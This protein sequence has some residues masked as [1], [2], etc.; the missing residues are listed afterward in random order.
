[1]KK[2]V[3][4][5]KFFVPLLLFFFASCQKDIPEQPDNTKT[6]KPFK[7]GVKLSFLA[8]ETYISTG[9]G[10]S[11]PK[12]MAGKTINNEE[13][14]V[15]IYFDRKGKN[16][17]IITKRLDKDKRLTKNIIEPEWR[18]IVETNH[19]SI[20][21]SDNRKILFNL[22]N[23][24]KESQDLSYLVTPYP[25]RS[26]MMKE[27]LF[28]N[29]SKSDNITIE[30]QN[31]TTVVKISKVFEKGN[32][33][34]EEIA[35]YL[36]ISYVNVNYGVPVVSELY[37]PSGNLTSKVIILYKMVNN[38]PVAAYEESISYT[39]DYEGEVVEHK[40]ITN[41]ENINIENF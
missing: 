31:D 34:G 1:M 6:E 13:K 16:Y 10:K 40:A 17:Q 12:I 24:E 7:S 15:S 21:Y 27:M 3:I 22:P 29:G 2:H 32:E 39:V 5:L 36:A 11:E 35:G 33:F 20:T 19:G 41:Y 14:E 38:I 30:I 8:K 25:E 37:D 23:M 28:G 9:V 4:L 26:K 18:E